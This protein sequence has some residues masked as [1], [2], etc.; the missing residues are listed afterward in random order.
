MDLAAEAR[1]DPGH[2]FEDEVDDILSAKRISN[3]KPEMGNAPFDEE[4]NAAAGW[5]ARDA[6]RTF[7][8]AFASLLK[9]EERPNVEQKAF[10]E[11]SIRRL[12]SEVLEQRQRTIG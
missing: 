3:Q 10:L 6:E 11:H 5:Y 7:D 12:K 2:M 4:R 8:S 1:K 9:R